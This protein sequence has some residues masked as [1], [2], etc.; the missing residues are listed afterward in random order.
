MRP[1]SPVLTVVLVAVVALSPVTA[2]AGCPARAPE[3]QVA[4]GE[5]A[6]ARGDWPGAAGAFACAAAASDDAR[7]AERASR[8]ALEH[9]Q[10][11]P[12]ARAAGRWVALEPDSEEAR[13]HLATALLRLY[14]SDESIG[15]FAVVLETAWEDRAEGYS[16]LGTTLARESNKTGAARVMEHLA[17]GGAGLAEAQLARSVL[18]EQAEHGERALQA[19]RRALELRPGWRPAELAEV[20]ALLLLGRTEE[21][22][23]R[24]EQLALGGDALARLSLAWWLVGAGRDE[25]ARETFED[26]RKSGNAVPQALEGLGSLAWSQ[27]DYEGAKRIFTEL[28]QL[29]RGDPTSLAFLG[30]LAE[31]E[32]NPQLAVRLLE[33]VTS[34]PRAV[35][36]QLRAYRLNVELGV[37]E[38]AE[39]GLED[40][41]E[42]SPESARDVVS[43][44]AGQLA[45]QG[46]GAEAMALL[47][48]VA[49]RYPDDGDL[50]LGRAY[51]LDRLDRVPEAV[52]VMRDVLR[53]RPDDPT[54]LNALGYT[55]AD[56]TGRIA[57]GYELVRRAIEAR[58]DSYA[59]MDSMGWALFRLGRPLESLPWLE[60]AWQR[61]RDPEVAAHLGEVLWAQG[62]RE[63][64]R[65]LW[66]DAQA[67]S[68]DNRS[69][70]RT[71][72]RHQG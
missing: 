50:Q 19:A 3:A 25:Q 54:A 7:L 56:R 71:V 21:G 55:L 10:M 38:R 9:D 48:R 59:V 35:A 26:L 67:D 8:V 14:R 47:D 43:G 24:A 60:R 28:A 44:L 70:Q 2:A 30:L 40:F 52:A 69:L 42:R 68:P 12:A 22:I 58:P 63:E 29:S 37:P 23:G 39:Q 27:R 57:E 51:L 31:K 32:S 65:R 15:H 61:S 13:R 41:L 49:D 17:Q 16:A 33:R 53:R 6:L 11:G 34:G 62:R 36:S 1:E 18:W 72:A 64:A 20:R 45:D 4:T 66:T 5:R 46:R